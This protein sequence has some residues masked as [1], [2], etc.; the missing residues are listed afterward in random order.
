MTE[1]PP[2]H[3]RDTFMSEVDEAVRLSE[4]IARERALKGLTTKSGTT[5]ASRVEQMFLSLMH[6]M[7]LNEK[8]F[9]EAVRSIARDEAMSDTEQ[10]RK[11]IAAMSLFKDFAGNSADNPVI[12]EEPEMSLEEEMAS[13]S[14]EPIEKGRRW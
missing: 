12:I 3:V 8:E 13:I 9:F 10:S 2:H 7:S 1:A 5:V 6:E 11:F 14:R 4:K